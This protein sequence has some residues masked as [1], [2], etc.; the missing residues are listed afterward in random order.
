MTSRDVPT[1]RALRVVSGHRRGS[2]R[3]V[4]VETAQGCFL[5]KLTGAAQGTGPLVAEIIVAELA[6][7]VGLRVPP[8]A[9]LTLEPGLPSDDPDQ[10]LRE[11]L[12]DASHGLN[13]G[14]AFLDGARDIRPHEVRDAPDALAVPVLWLDA[15]VLNSDRTPANPNILVWQGEPWLI[16]HGASLP[17]Q[18]RWSAVTEDAPRRT[19]YPLQRHLF[20]DRAGRLAAWDEDLAARLGRDVLEHA[21][22]QVPDEFLAP[23]VEPG[24]RA[25]RLARR[26]RAYEAF[27][28]KRL[29]APRPFVP[30]SLEMS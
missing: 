28:W 26:R 23:L 29:K 17:F 11:D 27:L 30:S 1:H 19:D 10:E 15:L 13:L 14:F 22:A 4:V 21:V 18:Y 25:D 20:G 12:L 5:A 16:D 24:G 9:G 3:P 7:A 8:R 6:A 2:S